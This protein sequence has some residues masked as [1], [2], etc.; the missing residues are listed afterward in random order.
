MLYITEEWKKL[1]LEV[2]IIEA[3]LC[4][5]LHDMHNQLLYNYKWLNVSIFLIKD[6]ALPFYSE[7][8]KMNYWT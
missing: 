8:I 5:T 7:K 4:I 6:V 1:L 3:L 2:H